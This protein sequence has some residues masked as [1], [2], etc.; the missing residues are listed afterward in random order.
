[1]LKFKHIT[2]TS[3]KGRGLVSLQ[4]LSKKIGMSQNWDFAMTLPELREIRVWWFGEGFNSFQEFEPSPQWWLGMP[5]ITDF[6]WHWQV[7]SLCNCGIWSMWGKKR[8]ALPMYYWELLHIS[9][10]HAFF[11]FFFFLHRN[12][13]KTFKSMVQHPV[14][15]TVVFILKNSSKGLEMVL[16]SRHQSRSAGVLKTEMNVKRG[17]AQQGVCPL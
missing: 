16:Q 15:A 8:A 11:F 10:N 4:G 2:N 1:M 9:I 6:A 5:H 12:N 17:P 3:T 14:Q 13:R 7:W